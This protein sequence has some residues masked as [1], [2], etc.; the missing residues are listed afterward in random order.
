MTQCILVPFHTVK[1]RFNVSNIVVFSKITLAM[2]TNQLPA[3]VRE[4]YRHLV[5]ADP[6]FDKPNPVDM[7]IG[8]DLYPL[9][10]QSRAD[11][12]Y[13]PGLP[14]AIITQLGWIIVGALREATSSPLVS[15]SVTSVTA[16]E[17]LLHRFWTV[18]EP[19]VSETVTTQDN[20]SE[21]WFLRTFS[22]D[23]TGRFCVGLRSVLV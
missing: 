12:I 4:H 16:A 14:S 9:L 1:P 3:S 22:R 2:P 10:L 21:E 17:S 20:Q 18:Q 13:S 5:L 7:L 8:S 15:L 6:K 19:T 11:I 23:T